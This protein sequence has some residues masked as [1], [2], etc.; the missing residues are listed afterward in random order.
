[1]HFISQ[2][3]ALSSGK[4][5]SFFDKAGPPLHSELFVM[6]LPQGKSSHF[7]PKCSCQRTTFTFNFALACRGQCL[8]HWVKS[9]D[10]QI[11]PKRSPNIKVSLWVKFIKT[12]LN[13]LYILNKCFSSHGIWISLSRT[14]SWLN[15]TLTNINL[16]LNQLNQSNV[17]GRTLKESTGIIY[18][19]FK[20]KNAI[21]R[22]SFWPVFFGKKY[23]HTKS[24]TRVTLYNLK[25]IRIKIYIF[26]IWIFFYLQRT[27]C[28]QGHIQREFTIDFDQFVHGLRFKK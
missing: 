24:P 9:I 11:S 22:R 14:V 27:G 10:L 18:I 8:L 6:W 20:P 15:W 13:I 17:T 23:S 28:R 4:L 16:Q 2:W 26:F 3:C 1:M 19:W 12:N 7:A 5:D 25:L 21:F